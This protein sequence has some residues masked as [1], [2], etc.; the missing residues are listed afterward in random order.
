MSIIHASSTFLDLGLQPTTLSEGL[1]LEVEQIAARYRDRADMTKI[2]ATSLWTTKHEAGVP[3]NAPDRAG[4]R[5]TG[6]DRTRSVQ[7]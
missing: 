2:P 4:P 5:H 3:A 6:G 7:T 1:L